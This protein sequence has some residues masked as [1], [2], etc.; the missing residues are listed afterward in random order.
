MILW[1]YS[2]LYIVAASPTNTRAV[3]LDAT[4][5]QVTWSKPYPLDETNGYKIS[6]TGSRSGELVVNGENTEEG[7]LRNLLNGVRYTISIAGISGHFNSQ[8]VH[9]TTSVGLGK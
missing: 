2:I 3:Q 5:I 6:Y 4:S 8:S 1:G 7:I 9:V